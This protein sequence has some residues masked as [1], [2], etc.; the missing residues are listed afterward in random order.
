M[1]DDFVFYLTDRKEAA[2]RFIRRP[3]NVLVGEGNIAKFDCRIIAASAPI[4][5]W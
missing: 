4:V 2:P 1:F 5:T 3:R